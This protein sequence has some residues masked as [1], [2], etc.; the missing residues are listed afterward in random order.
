MKALRVLFLVVLPL[1]TAAL[2]YPAGAA[3]SRINDT[4]RL[5]EIV[6]AG[7]PVEGREKLES[8]QAFSA[9]QSTLIERPEVVALVTPLSGDQAIEMLRSDAMAVQ[10][11][12]L[13]G[14]TLLGF[15]CGLVAS[16]RVLAAGRVKQRKEY[17]IER[18]QCVSCG[19]CF[20]YCPVERQKRKEGAA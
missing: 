12:F 18:S 5:A 6:A 9:Y 14:G 8:E 16:I 2:G 20:A 11:K 1:A 7:R 17:E 4:V 13:I 10:R 3:L 19:R 15:W